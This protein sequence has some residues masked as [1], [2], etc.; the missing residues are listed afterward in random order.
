MYYFEI[1]M[2]LLSKLLKAELEKVLEV[3]CN[4]STKYLNWKI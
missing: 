3:F 2:E 1:F 4:Y